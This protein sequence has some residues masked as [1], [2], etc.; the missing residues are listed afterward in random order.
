MH[1]LAMLSEGL[2]P[3]CNTKLDDLC[4]CGSGVKWDIKRGTQLPG[5]AWQPPT[6]RSIK[7]QQQRLDGFTRPGT[8]RYEKLKSMYSDSAPWRTF[9]PKEGVY[10][11]DALYH[12]ELNTN[13]N[14][15]VTEQ[16][17]P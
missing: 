2:C 3:L 10:K 17:A 8:E 6:Y 5:S 13:G 15:I 7:S 4:V 16:E 9:V 11:P 14:Y 1:C 12:I